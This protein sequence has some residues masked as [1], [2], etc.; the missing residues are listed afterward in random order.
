MQGKRLQI[1]QVSV[2][3]NEGRFAID[4]Q[5]HTRFLFAQ[6]G[7]GA[8]WKFVIRNVQRSTRGLGFAVGLATRPG[9][10]FHLGNALPSGLGV[11]ERRVP[12][13]GTKP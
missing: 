5:E 1:C 4:H 12:D 10:A 3:P 8:L 9:V 13:G 7:G 2:A 11:V 6:S